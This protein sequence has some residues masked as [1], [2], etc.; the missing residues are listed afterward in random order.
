MDTWYSLLEKIKFDNDELKML[1]VNDYCEGYS[2]CKRLSNML[3]YDNNFW[4]IKKMR[5]NY[6]TSRLHD[7]SKMEEL[8]SLELCFDIPCIRYLDD[9]KLCNKLTC[10]KLYSCILDRFPSVICDLINLE[11]LTIVHF[12]FWSIPNDMIKLI[13]LETL[14]LAHGLK[15]EK[16]PLVLCKI[17]SLKK[18]I[19]NSCKIVT[20]P[21]L[22]Y[23]LQKLEYLCMDDNILD[24]LPSSLIKMQKLKTMRFNDNNFMTLPDVLQQMILTPDVKIDMNHNFIKC[25]PTKYTFT[26]EEFF[27]IVSSILSGSCTISITTWI[28]I[29]VDHSYTDEHDKSYTHVNYLINPCVFNVKTMNTFMHPYYDVNMLIDKLLGSFATAKW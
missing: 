20:I 14:I 18:L 17:K 5:I 10:L 27:D 22:I 16:I 4:P 3:D 13:N 19:I 7:I 15:F 26:K 11:E 6:K 8:K 25:V 23:K 2:D 9:V 21:N 12:Y 1:N 29:R 28:V 24:S